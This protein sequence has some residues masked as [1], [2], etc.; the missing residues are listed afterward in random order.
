MNYIK[1]V[2]ITILFTMIS[3][4]ITFGVLKTGLSSGN[5]GVDLFIYVFGC[6]LIFSSLFCVLDLFKKGSS[7]ID[8]IS[9]LII[10]IVYLIDSGIGILLSK[11]GISLPKDD[12]MLAIMI[13]VPALLWIIISIALGIIGKLDVAKRCEQLKREIEERKKEEWN[14]IL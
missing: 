6:G 9:F 5:N 8:K 1:T 2:I 14:D 12:I 3:T 4:C 11:T 10:W 7:G 13:A